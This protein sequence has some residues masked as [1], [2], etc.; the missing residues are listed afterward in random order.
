MDNARA[1]VQ[2]RLNNDYENEVRYL[3]DAKVQL[4][5]SQQEV[6]NRIERVKEY[7]RI[8]NLCYGGPDKPSD[9]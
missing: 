2:R 9:E 4:K 6:D 5:T 3:N 1:V 7:E 8:I